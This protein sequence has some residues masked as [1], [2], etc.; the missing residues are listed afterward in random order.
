MQQNWPWL[1]I[2]PSDWTVRF[3]VVLYGVAVVKHSLIVTKTPKSCTG[4]LVYSPSP[5]MKLTLPN[6]KKKLNWDNVETRRQILKAEMVYKS[7]NGLSPD[8][9]FIPR[10]D[11]NNRY[12]LWNSANK[13]AVPLPRTNCYKNSFS[14]GGAAVPWKRL[15]SNVR[16]Q[17]R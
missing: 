7:L 8:C 12:D 15:P 2:L 11:I 13:L 5:T 9:K 14:Y 4:G 1:R 10:S 16:R 3:C 6:Y 17:P